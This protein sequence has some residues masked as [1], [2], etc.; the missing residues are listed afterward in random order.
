MLSLNKI[1]FDSRLERHEKERRSV[2]ETFDRKTRKKIFGNNYDVKSFIRFSVWCWCDVN[3]SAF[4]IWRKP[5]FPAYRIHYHHCVTYFEMKIYT[6][7]FELSRISH[8][9]Q[10][11]LLRLFCFFLASYHTECLHPRWMDQ[12]DQSS[13]SSKSKQ[14]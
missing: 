5:T 1:G 4:Y 2:S 12:L 9:S 13:R 11:S 10:H 14:M 7:N 6:L 3:A 8:C